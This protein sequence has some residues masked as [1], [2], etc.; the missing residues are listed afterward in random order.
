MAESP[1]FKPVADMGSVPLTE[2]SDLRFYVDEYRGHRYGSIR[3]FVRRQN[4]SGPTKAGVTMNVGI[5]EGVLEAVSK[6]PPEPAALADA[7]L[8]RLPKRA[9]VTLVV[10]IT[11]YKDTTGVDLR[12]WVED[13]N[14]K[15]WSKKGVRIPYAELAKARQFLQAMRDALAK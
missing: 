10:R 15:G 14:Y 1:E 6:L 7:E 12:E 9:G 4:Y 2:D 11:L 3:T 13:L 5:I 8:A